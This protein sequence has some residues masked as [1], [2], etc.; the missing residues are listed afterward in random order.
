MIE[1]GKWSSLYMMVS[2]CTMKRF[3]GNNYAQ[4]AQNDQYA[5]NSEPKTQYAQNNYVP[6]TPTSVQARPFYSYRI[7]CSQKTKRS[8]LKKRLKILLFNSAPIKK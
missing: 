5:Q 4:Y 2:K 7:L 6:F 1:K 8:S 3:T